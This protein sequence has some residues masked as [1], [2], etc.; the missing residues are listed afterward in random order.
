[1]ALCFG[2]DRLRAGADHHR[3]SSRGLVPS[4]GGKALSMLVES[5]AW[6]RGIHMLWFS[7]FSTEQSAVRLKLHLL[8]T[9]PPRS[10]MARRIYKTAPCQPVHDFSSLL[11]PSSTTIS[12]LGHF[13]FHFLLL[14]ILN[15]I[16]PIHYFLCHQTITLTRSKTLSQKV[17]QA[18]YIFS[19]LDL[20]LSIIPNSK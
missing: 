17:L 7:C 20:S 9:N 10:K 3:S 15:L 14:F 1:M 6:R 13:H 2:R 5:A 16:V 19:I 8:V 4:F 12:F 11:T 18:P